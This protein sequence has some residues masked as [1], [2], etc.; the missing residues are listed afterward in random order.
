MRLVIDNRGYLMSALLCVVV[1]S[2]QFTPFF[3]V[4]LIASF[5]FGWVLARYKVIE[6]FTNPRKR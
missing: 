4:G 1:I 6:N 3:E 2:L 5:I